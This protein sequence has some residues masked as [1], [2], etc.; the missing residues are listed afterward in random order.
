MQTTAATTALTKRRQFENNI[1]LIKKKNT[2]TQ[3]CTQQIVYG[4]ALWMNEWMNTDECVCVRLHSHS[5]LW[6]SLEQ[7]RKQCSNSK[8]SVCVCI[9]A[10]TYHF[11]VITTVMSEFLLCTY[12]TS[13]YSKRAW[14]LRALNF[15]PFFS[16][17]I[18]YYIY[19]LLLLFLLPK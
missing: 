3:S 9:N 5:N 19:T 15:F 14:N 12:W 8:Y 7:N 16:I 10:L 11:V 2:A 17:R 6:I 18:P 1:H 4:N 13:M